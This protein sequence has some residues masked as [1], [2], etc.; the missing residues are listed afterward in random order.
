VI[1]TNLGERWRARITLD[2]GRYGLVVFLVV[3]FG[4]FA[5]LKPHS[6]GTIDNVRAVLDNQAIV[7]IL[8]LAAMIPLIVGEFDLS[9][10]SI[11][12][13]SAALVVGL[14][15]KEGLDPV[16]AIIVTESLAIGIGAFNGLV[17]V[18]LRVNAFVVTLG[19]S[20]VLSGIWIWYLN[21]AVIVANLPSAFTGL[22][23]YRLMGIPYTVLF[24]AG[25]TGLLWGVMNLLPVGRRMYATGA[26]RRAAFLSGINTARLTVATFVASGA[27]AGVGGIILGARL[28]SA[29]GGTGSELLLPAF[30]GA[31]LGATT[32]RPGRFNVIGTVVAVYALAFMIAGLQQIGA[33][34][35]VTPVFNG[36]GLIIAVGL[37]RWASLI[38]SARERGR[39]LA[40]LRAEV[41]DGLDRRADGQVS[42]VDA[43][44]PSY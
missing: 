29:S 39:Q 16:V 27:L 14:Q 42:T 12:A 17:V 38:A 21:N 11:L 1:G 19:T 10:A 22:G 33:S 5:I 40:R 23:R 32:I 44:E 37:S 28:G 30:A 26:N 13:L 3:V 31:F 7:V 43:D 34:I 18:G 15:A 41:D 8:A 25:I 20:T 2:L 4:T 35:W 24:A 6:Y 9:G 36:A